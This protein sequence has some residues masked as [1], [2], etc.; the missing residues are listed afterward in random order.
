M[1]E[2]YGPKRTM[3]KSEWDPGA[4]E[5]TKELID[6]KIKFCLAFRGW[7]HL[8]WLIRCSGIPFTSLKIIEVGCGTGTLSL[9]FALAG[10]SV[11]L[12]D[13]N[14]NMLESAKKIYALYGCRA[15]FI[16]T[17]CLAEPPAELLGKFDL[18][19]SAGL[20]EHFRDVDRKKVIAY[21]R[22]LLKVGGIAYIGVPN[23]WSPFYQ[24]IRLARILTGT[25][26]SSVEIPFS[27][28]E[29]KSAAKETGFSNSYVLG[30]ASLVKDLVVYSRG[31]ISVIAEALPGT[32]SKQ[33]KTI[34]H[35]L[36]KEVNATVQDRCIIEETVK[37]SLD[38][39]AEQGRAGAVAEAIDDNFSAGIV[40]FAFR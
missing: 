7:K 4:T 40:L 33:L 38:R 23:R 26:K 32:L 14:R 19:I 10:A 17:D 3:D 20:V 18:A 8:A 25:W 24:W 35:S 6:Q 30:N 21:H 27:S 22:L 12:I 37:T 39:S 2:S 16:E 1:S 34:K 36:P 28:R 11:T 31:F 9:I 13:F 15:E 5:F 29:L